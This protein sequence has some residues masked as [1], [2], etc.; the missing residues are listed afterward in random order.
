MGRAK[1]ARPALAG[2]LMHDET[3]LLANER[4][5]L[6]TRRLP[7]FALGW[8]GTVGIWLIVFALEGSQ[9]PQTLLG[10]VA[11]AL[12]LGAA[13]ALCRRDPTAPRVVPI[14][15]GACVL[16][17]LASM[18]VVHAVGANGEILA[19]MLL[20]LYLASALL[21]SWG[22]SAELALLG[23][24]LVPWGLVLGRFTFFVPLPELGAAVTIGAAVAL[25]I[26]EGSARSVRAVARRR[27]AQEQVTRE[28]QQSRDAYR[29]LAEHARDLI[30]STDR[31]GRLVYVNEAMTRFLGVD[32]GELLGRSGGDFL[33]GHAENPRFGNITHGE[34]PD[35]APPFLIQCATPRGPR[36]VEVVVSV[37]RDAH[38]TPIGFRGI[39]RDVHERREAETALRDSEARYRSLL[40]SQSELVLRFDLTGRVV[41]AND[42][43]V[44][45]FG[46]D[47]SRAYGRTFFHLIPVEDHAAV[48]SAFGTL[49]QP[50]HRIAIEVRGLTPDGVRWI[51]WEGGAVLDADGRPVEYQSA[52]R[53]V[54]ERRAGEDALRASEAR[55]RGLVESARELVTRFDR[56]GNLTFANDAYC[57]AIGYP[58]ETMVGRNPMFLVHP[59]DRDAVMASFRAA[60]APPYRARR[61]SRG[62]TPAGWRWFE[63]ELSGVRDEHDRVL[64]IQQVG[65]D[66]TARRQA[67]ADLRESEER[68]RRAFEDAAIGMGVTTLEGR[69]I[70][71]NRALCE[72][73]GYSEP[74]LLER[75]VDDIVH[76]DDRP[77]VND[78]RSRLST[79]QTPSY[80]AERRYIR[81]DGRQIWV[82]VTASVVRDVAGTPLYLVGQIQDVTERRLA[83][84]ALHESLVDL[85]RSEEKLRLLARRQVRIREEERKRLG[86]DLHDDVCQE[87]VG[88]GILVESLRRKL[89][90]MPAEHSA[91]FERVVGYLGEV[92]EHLRLLARELRPLL[93]RDLGLDGSL[94]ALADG[95]SS[96]IVRVTTAFAPAIPR[97]D[98]E[99]EL[100]VYRIA[101][102]ALANAVRHA[103][104]RSIVITLDTSDDRLA[105]VVRDDG[106]GFDPATRPAVALGLASMEERA[107]ALGGQLDIRSVPGTGTTVT[108][109]CPI[110]PRKPGR[111][112]ESADPSPTRSSPRPSTKTKP[113]SAARD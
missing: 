32:E 88:V 56:A 112:R 58:R 6:I 62:L 12:V 92:V 65:R 43:Y 47:R 41:F 75:S 66:M 80:R 11:Q 82:H 103:G 19:F 110:A 70:R 14:V 3:S 40:E 5:A 69:T 31:D 90:P 27:H 108:L 44:A 83:E 107:L 15:V 97:F 89:A 61:E 9:S 71:A 17:G 18:L 81:K 113:R 35:E 98:E 111:V 30:W 50:P 54:T 109:S 57:R 73:L 46:E 68:F 25:V 99:S 28:L 1:I 100:T 7:Q 8:L 53:D 76:P 20:T 85:Q 55:Y 91:E 16:L 45:A 21:F 78:D 26:A 33:T 38:G 101:Q 95:M 23:L 13:L 96:A 36:W 64:E 67:E 104:A 42:A 86:F 63:W 87:L 2:A 102:E 74:E 37:A 34:L 106:R 84:V 93:L 60:G 59:D 49:A 29:D 79:A 22:W 24:T 4:S 94:R 77:L 51:A 72:M 10:M 39:S 52:G 48:R 105:L